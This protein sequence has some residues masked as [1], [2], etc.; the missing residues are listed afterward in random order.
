MPN[1]IKRQ[2]KRAMKKF[3]TL[4]IISLPLALA[5]QKLTISEEI[6]L[7]NDVSYE[8]IGSFDD[9]ILLFR[10]RVSNFDVEAFGRDMRQTWTKELKLEKRNPKIIGFART[11]TSFTVFFHH[12]DKGDHI[13][14][15]YTYDP[16]ANLRDTM[17]LKNLGFTFYT[18]DYRIELSEDRNK[19]LLYYLEN[20]KTI[21]TT[22]FDMITRQVLWDKQFSPEDLTF[23]EEFQQI[24]LDDSGTMY[25][26]LEKNRFRYRR[27]PHYHEV[28]MV[29]EEATTPLRFA[30]P[31]GEERTTF[32]VRFAYDNMNDN[33]VAA[34]L[35]AERSVDRA[36]G[37]YYMRIDPGNP[38]NL[39]LQ[40]EEFKDDFITGLQGKRIEDNKGIRDVVVQEIVLR[41]DGGVLMVAELSHEQSRFMGT[42]RAFANTGSR[43]IVDHYFDDI[44][45]IS[46]HP[47]GETHWE[48]TLYKKQYSQDDGAIFSSFFLFKTTNSLHF[49]YNDEI[50][51]ENTV[52]EYVVFGD[53]NFDR[54]SL[55]S[56]ENLDL[57]LRFRD[58]T[59]ISADEL[60]IPSER[61]NR[62]RLV[63]LEYE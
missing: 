33:L 1:F 51:F 24:I 43:Q 34:G 16:A 36:E 37:Y 9:R 3:I 27:D 58:A 49:I 39:I 53:G 47:N 23:W 63:R 20:Q 44:F 13:L 4:L 28:W 22:A 21:H 18:P 10:N 6:M 15:A 38:G 40:F 14:K 26:I 30:I 48:T 62:L 8:I 2:I 55:L 17:T 25:L 12:R 31:M 54:R 42:G 60:I 35:Y 19:V 56:T 7:R 32:D 29:N 5:A 46:I 50:K 57:R 41:R 52:S 11:D 59:Q 45:V 61:R